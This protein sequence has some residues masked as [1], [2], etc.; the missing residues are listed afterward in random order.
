MSVGKTP[1][2]LRKQLGRELARLRSY[3]GLDQRTLGSQVDL[4]QSTVSRAE[5][6]EKLLPLPKV[7]AW[8]QVCGASED[9]L[10]R[11]TELTEAA[12]TQSEAWRDLLADT[13]H[14]QDAVQANEAT[15]RTL[16]YYSP[17]VIPGL[18]Q[19]P[20]YAEHVIRMTNYTGQEDE[21][22][23]LMGRW[24]R[25]EVLSDRTKHFGF[26]LPELVLRWVPAAD[27]VAMLL[28]LDRVITVA[29]QDNVS[30]SVIPNG[31]EPVLPFHGFTIYA[32]RD[33]DDPFVGLELV[34]GYI[35]VDHPIDVES[36]RDIYSRMVISALT[37]PDA[38]AL[39][40][41]VASELRGKSDV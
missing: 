10:R 23:A 34:H 5:R 14:L 11:L 15:A 12:F 41:R 4:K 28:Q 33:G 37:G 17:T 22:A 24:R 36:Y 8:A 38:V 31:A 20:A 19:T 39:I 3:A 7:L 25:Q 18:L 16:L 27:R 26:L 1:S 35:T 2:L 6:A 21:D 40:Q 9:M 29:G 32:D 30:L 13:V